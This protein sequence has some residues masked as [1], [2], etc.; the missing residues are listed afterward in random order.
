MAKL[1]DN[2]NFVRI[3]IGRSNGQPKA[4][5]TLPLKTVSDYPETYLAMR[6]RNAAKC[7]DCEIDGQT[8]IIEV[9]H[10]T[11][12]FNEVVDWYYTNSYVLPK[13]HEAEMFYKVLDFWMIPH[14][15]NACQADP[16]DILDKVG[17]MV[18]E[19]QD[20]KLAVQHIAERTQGYEF[21]DGKYVYVG[22][23]D[24]DGCDGPRGRDGCDGKRRPPGAPG[25]R[26]P[27]GHR[28][29]Q[30]EK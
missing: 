9:Y 14:Q 1:A 30:G 26:G 28:G 3:V 10:T 2:I 11:R 5:A 23:R 12:F 20:I 24:R 18:T 27:P 17:E 25:S 16:R 21:K 29:P 7:F 13:A 4:E 15:K 22:L 19:M 8:I 6:L